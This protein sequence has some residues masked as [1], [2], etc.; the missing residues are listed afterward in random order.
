M[1]K[2]HTGDVAHD[3]LSLSIML[4]V[5]CVA[6]VMIMS[7]CM[8]STKPAQQQNFSTSSDTPV[9]TVAQ[10]DQD[11]DG[12]ISTA[13]AQQLTTNNSNHVVVFL[14]I[15]CCVIVVCVLC[16]IV[17]HMVKRRDISKN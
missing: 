1:N 12:Q 2:R 6:M 9:I 13:E 11:Q 5:T 3:W 17:G 7:S 16:A 8:I 15:V 14:S 10:L 4:I